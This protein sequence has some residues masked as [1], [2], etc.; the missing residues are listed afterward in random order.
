MGQQQPH[1]DSA[2]GESENF[3]TAERSA[4]RDS[5]SATIVT[6]N[7]EL[8]HSS[9]GC[10]GGSL[11]RIHPMDL[12]NN[13]IRLDGLET[14][15]GREESCDL[16]LNHPSISRK[17]AVIRA[18]AVGYRLEDSGSTNGTYV[19]EKSVQSALLV[20]GVRIRFGNYIYRFLSNDSIETTYHETVYSMMT[21]DGLTGC[22]NKRYLMEI[23]E[24]EFQRCR[25]SGRPSSLLMMD[26]D[27]FKEVN[28][29]YGHLAGDD[30]LKEFVSR[31]GALVRQ[32]DVF[33]RYGGEEFA[34]IMTDAPLAGAEVCAKALRREIQRKPFTTCA[35]DLSCTVSV[36]VTE[37][38]FSRHETYEDVIAE[39]D[40]RLYEAK[41]SGRNQVSSGSVASP[42]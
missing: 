25:R 36:G 42:E 13:L 39:A 35:G 5:V 32:E 34:L 30:V 6:N 18:T 3:P 29:S 11:V 17:H 16:Y 19:D 2:L 14:T 21:K 27:H 23:L 20:N 12:H 33:A 1:S 7:S 26:L 40:S 10:N 9:T 28:D 41:A 37:F 22:F 31:V 15:I 4:P 38:D 24:R 8:R